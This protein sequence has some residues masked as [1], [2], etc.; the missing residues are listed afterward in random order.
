MGI[1]DDIV[2]IAVRVDG[3][4]KARR[5]EWNILNGPSFTDDSVNQRLD[6]DFSVIGYTV[7]ATKTANYTAA[8]GEVVMCDPSG[9]GFTVTLPAGNSAKRQQVAV[10][11]DTNSTNTITVDTP[12]AETIDGVATDSIASAR[13]FT[14]YISGEDRTDWIVA[15]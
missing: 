15:G 11:N 10:K 13:G 2:G 5:R 3:A 1:L 7:T 6:V 12:G 8:D 4:L 9:G 14:V